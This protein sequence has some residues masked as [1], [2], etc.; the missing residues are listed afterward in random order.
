MYLVKFIPYVHTDGH[1]CLFLS[2]FFQLIALKV[3]L[4]CYKWQDSVLFYGQIVFH[5]VFILQVSLSIHSLMDTWVVSVS[6]L[7]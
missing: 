2:I 3:H 7:L 5:C 1:I 6:W 4:C